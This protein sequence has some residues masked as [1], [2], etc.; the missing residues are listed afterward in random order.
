MGQE[1]IDFTDSLAA[2][3]RGEARAADQ[4]MPAL[5]DRLRRLATRLMSEERPGHTLQPTALVHEAYLRLVDLSRIRWRE[6]NHFYA[7][8]ARQMRRVL[9]DHARRRRAKKR[10]GGAWNVMLTEGMAVDSGQLLDIL[11][12]DE[13]LDRLARR[14]SRQSRVAEFRI[15]GGMEI[16][17]IACVLQVSERTVTDDWQYARVWLARE[18]SAGK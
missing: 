2:H 1:A 6:K 10:G 7:M 14:R 12:L 11:A 5:Y 16:K 15:F 3:A 18:L 9:R 8:A 13:A 17:E 4:L